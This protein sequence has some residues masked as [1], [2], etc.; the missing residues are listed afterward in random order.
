MRYTNIENPLLNIQLCLSAQNTREPNK[1]IQLQAR[2]N[3]KYT[4][5]STCKIWEFRFSPVVLQSGVKT[6]NDYTCRKLVRFTSKDIHVPRHLFVLFLRTSFIF[7]NA[8]EKENCVVLSERGMLVLE[9]QSTFYVSNITGVIVTFI[10]LIFPISIIDASLYLCLL[11][12]IR[13]YYHVVV[14]KYLRNYYHV[15]VTTRLRF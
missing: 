2:L 7:I 14:T 4:L 8:A 11:P 9:V 13:N 12:R 15:V 6:R 3:K 5:I 1:R 10:L